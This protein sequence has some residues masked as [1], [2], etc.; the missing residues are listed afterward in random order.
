M[1]GNQIWIRHESATQ[2]DII[3]TRYYHLA[4]KMVKKGDLVERGQ[5]I[6]TLGGT[7]ALA[8]NPHLHFETQL[9]ISEKYP[10]KLKPLNPH[11]FW[12][13]GKGKITCFNKNRN[14]DTED[15]RLTYP[16]PCKSGT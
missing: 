4:K 1:Y 11:F 2:Q 8:P 3:I 6:G 14:W 16:V 15:F 13:D 5:D 9:L 7:G 12:W 10:A